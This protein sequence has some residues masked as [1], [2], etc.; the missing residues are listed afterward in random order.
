M[1]KR[2][3]FAA[4]LSLV[5]CASNGGA[6][7]SASSADEV[8][9]A[10]LP[11]AS[12]RTVT[13]SGAD[14]IARHGETIF[15]TDF[16]NVELRSVPLA[17]GA[18]KVLWKGRTQPMDQLGDIALDD[19]DIY[20]VEDGQIIRIPQ[21]GGRWDIVIRNSKDF[22]GDIDL[23]DHF[24]Y[25]TTGTID[26]ALIKRVAKEGGAPEVVYD[27]P[28]GGDGIAVKDGFVYFFGLDRTAP[29]SDKTEYLM[30]V[31]AKPH[32]AVT[33]LARIENGARE[34][35]LAG[36]EI[37]FAN[38]APVT[39]GAAPTWGIRAVPKS[40]GQSRTVAELGESNDLQ[41]YSLSAAGNDL[42]WSQSMTFDWHQNPPGQHDAKV[43]TTATSGSAPPRELATKLDGAPLL[44]VAENACPVWGGRFEIATVDRCR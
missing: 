25:W 20:F 24:V 31:E 27:G 13:S 15:Y 5:A 14:A 4:L 17:G 7:D 11:A 35:A 32:G 23:D 29:D 41:P 36:D 2:A 28:R 38:K 21:E 37:F 6:N 39:P 34:I 19:K 8:K 10:P 43:F 44:A 1:L 22:P 40:G 18:S 42:Y 33:E 9:G 26:H 16:Q 30:K 12:V 3:S